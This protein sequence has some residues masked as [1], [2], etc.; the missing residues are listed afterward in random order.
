MVYSISRSRQEDGY[1]FLEYRIINEDSNHLKAPMNINGF[2]YTMS[3]SRDQR[4][5]QMVQCTDQR[6]YDRLPFSRS[7]KQW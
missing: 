7:E 6:L 2:Q 4:R 5:D 3:R 1:T